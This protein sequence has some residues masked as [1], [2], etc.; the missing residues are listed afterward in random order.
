MDSS[1]KGNYGLRRFL[2]IAFWMNVLFSIFIGC[3]GESESDGY[4]IFKGPINKCK[5]DKECASGSYCDTASHRCV[6][7]TPE[8]ER[9]YHVKVTSP[10]T[11]ANLTAQVY[12]PQ[13]SEYIQKIPLPESERLSIN[14]VGVDAVSELNI[15]AEI[16]LADTGD[17]LPGY[18][19]QIFV[20]NDYGQGANGEKVP[21][22]LKLVTDLKRYSMTIVPKSE[23]TGGAYIEIFPQRYFDEVI[24]TSFGFIYQGEYHTEIEVPSAA[25][26]VKGQIKRGNQPV[27]NLYVIAIDPET[28]VPLSTGAL[29]VTQDSIN[30][31]FTLRL[32]PDAN[33]FSLKVSMPE[34]RWYPTN[35][36]PGFSIS[37]TDTDSDYTHTI[38]VPPLEPIPVPVR[39]HAKVE[40]EVRLE[41][42]LDGG[43]VRD[44]FPDCQIIFESSNIAGGTATQVATTNEE[45]YIVDQDSFP[46]IEIYPGEYQITVIPPNPL[47]LSLSDYEILR[48]VRDIRAPSEGQ[49]MTVDFRPL[50]KIRVT[51]EGRAMPWC[52]VSAEPLE[53]DPYWRPQKG[54]T[55]KNGELEI[56]L[57]RGNYRITAMPVPKTGYAWTSQSIEITGDTE[58][59]LPLALPFITYV[60]IVGE[61]AGLGNEEGVQGTT[62]EWYQVEGDRAFPVGRSEAAADG[63][64]EALLAP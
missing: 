13:N 22:R 17:K 21:A 15:K 26:M 1:G 38:D 54:V 31:N 18:L 47:P 14:V 51:A 7:P 52:S 50:V 43:V 55:N 64:V 37:D 10:K 60:E 36:I 25:T 24:F 27:N 34:Q 11:E 2:Q 4:S 40:K 12:V 35:V 32:A 62:V 39:Y 63:M 58:L 5:K 16:I 20:F 6:V 8:V 28:G 46:G 9:E 56:W 45:G 19:P 23:H 42:S 3:S 30:G 29:T 59:E 33:V 61:D 48:E 57:D 44:G 49:V 53:A 41:D